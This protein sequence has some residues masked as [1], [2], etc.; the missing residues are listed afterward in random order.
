MS[1]A[2]EKEGPTNSQ[3]RELQSAYLQTRLQHTLTHTQTASRLIYVVDGAILAF[4]YFL[5][6]DL[7]TV[8]SEIR[9]I[10]AVFVGLLAALNGLHA[11]FIYR[12]RFWYHT[13]DR[14]AREVLG[15]GD[16]LASSREERGPVLRLIFSTHFTYCVMHLLVAMVLCAFTAVLLIGSPT[17]IDSENSGSVVPGNSAKK[18]PAPVGCP[19]CAINGCQTIVC[20]VAATGASA[21]A[22]TSPPAPVVEQLPRG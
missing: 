19:P 1:D 17:A 21:S 11:W 5:L 8:T 2:G 13:I 16:P 10:A 7:R 9:V 18:P 6:K 22:G 14:Q 3:L 15:L 4:V 12:Q 20:A